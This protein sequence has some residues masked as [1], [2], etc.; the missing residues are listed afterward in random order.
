[1]IFRSLSV[2]EC[3]SIAESRRL[4][5]VFN[6]S[7]AFSFCIDFLASVELVFYFFLFISLT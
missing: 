6:S 1:M 4:F 2:V 5:L 3:D 7:G